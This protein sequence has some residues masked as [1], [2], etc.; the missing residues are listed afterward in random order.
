MI[1]GLQFNEVMLTVVGGVLNALIL[2]ILTWVANQIKRI[3]RKLQLQDLKQEATIYALGK[4]MGK[5]E[6]ERNEKY[7]FNCYDGK[8]N[9]LIQ[10]KKFIN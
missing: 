8:V 9:D 5:P 7:F 3:S 10:E 6:D 2:F 1:L 4:W